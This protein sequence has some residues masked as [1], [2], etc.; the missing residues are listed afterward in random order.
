MRAIPGIY[1]AF[2]KKLFTQSAPGWKKLTP[3][4][5]ILHP[6]SN[7]RLKRNFYGFKERLPFLRKHNWSAPQDCR[8]EG[9]PD[10]CV[11]VNH[12]FSAKKAFYRRTFNHKDYTTPR[13]WGQVK[14]RSKVTK[15][16]I[17]RKRKN[18]CH[19]FIK[20]DKIRK[21]AEEYSVKNERL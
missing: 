10:D 5:C 4:P 15:L 16:Y 1:E 6:T 19:V 17:G 18:P 21:K 12:P 13:G 9:P 3:S 11:I 14:Y 8:F 7:R 2:F 20:H